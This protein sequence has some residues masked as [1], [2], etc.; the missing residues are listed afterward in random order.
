MAEC[1][2]SLLQ[3]ES[4]FGQ[5]PAE[6]AKELERGHPETPGYDILDAWLHQ[7]LEDVGYNAIHRISDPQPETPGIGHG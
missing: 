6:Q 1:C 2:H 7:N 3:D 5:E 4:V